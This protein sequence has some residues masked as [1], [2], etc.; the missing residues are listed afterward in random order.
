[1]II[2][3]ISPILIMLDS[4]STTTTS[5]RKATKHRNLQVPAQLSHAIFIFS[6]PGL[7]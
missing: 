7:R 1:M 6:K 2:F 5:P 3:S 4:F